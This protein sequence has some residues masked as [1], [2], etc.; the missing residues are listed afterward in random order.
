MIHYLSEKDVQQVLNMQILLETTERSLKDRALHQAIDIPRQRIYTPEGTQHV[1]QAS[2]T[3]IGYT[4]FKYYYTRPSGKS[5][6]VHLISIQTGKL[7]AIV[8]AIWMSMIRTGAASGA[9]TKYLAREDA[10]IVGQI[11]S[12]YQSIGQLEAVCAVRKIK[13]ARVYSRTRDKLEAY[14]KKMSDKLGIAV[15]PA[16]SAE[17]AVRDVHI[18]NVVTKSA[19]P[20][21][22]GEWLTPGIHINAAGSNALS[23]A[24]IDDATVKRCDYITVDARGTAQKECGDLISSFEKGVIQ[25]DYLTEIGDVYAGKAPGRTSPTQITLYESHGMGIQDLYAAAKAYELAKARGLGVT[26]PVGL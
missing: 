18:L 12:G 26:L 5:F 1:L 25:W 10:S 17:A 11:G 24:E 8:E 9:A 3:A 21:I 13:Q 7:E 6:Y 23:R 4:G 19:T 15:V 2:S 22:K 14:C 16:A 20:T